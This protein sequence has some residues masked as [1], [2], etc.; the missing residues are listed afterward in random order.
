MSGTGAKKNT[1][2]HTDNYPSFPK[3]IECIYNALAENAGTDNRLD[4]NRDIFLERGMLEWLGVFGVKPL[5]PLVSGQV[6]S[7]RPVA[8]T[9]PDELIILFANMMGGVSHGI[10]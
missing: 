9:S 4:N 6:F 3:G 7:M 10:L 2:D 5:S 8:D 1:V